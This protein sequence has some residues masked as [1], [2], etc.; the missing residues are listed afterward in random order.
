MVGFKYWFAFIG[1][2][3]SLLSL[4]AQT[5]FVSLPV[6]TTTYNDTYTY[7]ILTSGASAREILLT[8]GALP[9]GVTLVD[10]GDGSGLL[11]GIVSQTGSFPLQLTVREIADNSQQDV[12]NFTLVVAKANASI[13]ISNLNQTYSSTGKQ[14]A[15]STVPAGLSVD[16]TYDG[17]ATPPVNAGTYAIEAAVSD[18]NYQGT[19]N[20]MLV[21]QKA[22]LQ[23][24]AED[25]AKLYGDVNP[26]LT[27]AYSGFLG[28]DDVS[29]I[30]EPLISTTATDGS[31]AG[32]YAIT[33]SG[34]SALNYDIT[35]VNGTLTVGK[36]TLTATADNKTRVYGSSNPSLEERCVGYVC[37]SR[38]SPFH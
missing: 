27:I 36:A 21:V 6:I 29:S 15:V 9:A 3:F 16:V 11:S 1:F 35:L 20:A 19:A 33:L 10:N 28:S 5:S 31:N 7:A 24:L 37:R 13:T 8:G 2:C 26:A 18:I 25:K 32:T 14:V 23:A 17:S 38:W 34:G 4:Q 12:Q 22:S 30:S